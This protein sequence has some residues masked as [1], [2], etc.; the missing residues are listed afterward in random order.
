[1]LYFR[2][3][4]QQ[5]VR[6]QQINTDSNSNNYNNYSNNYNNSNNNKDNSGKYQQIA[7]HQG[8]P[9]GNKPQGP[10]PFP[11]APFC[12][13]TAPASPCYHFIPSLCCLRRRRRRRLHLRLSR[14]SN[15]SL[16][17]C[18]FVEQ[19]IHKAAAWHVSCQ[20]HTHTYIC[21]NTHKVA[22]T[23]SQTHTHTWTHTWTEAGAVKRQLNQINY[24]C[25][26]CMDSSLASTA[27]GRASS[28]R[29][30]TGCPCRCRAR[31]EQRLDLANDKQWASV[32]KLSQIN[33]WADLLDELQRNV[34]EQEK[35]GGIEI[36]MKWENSTY[37][38]I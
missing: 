19:D 34:C 2:F 29:T 4:K 30:W 36:E 14:S 8:R 33:Y 12:F 1:M 3:I 31:L 10:L 25:F 17:A 9:I 32:D 35:D 22:R 13:L 24:T 38:Y 5:N 37:R 18:L 6:Q 16:F 15:S 21:T 11:V 7:G 28:G 20:P 23:H 27:R 26:H